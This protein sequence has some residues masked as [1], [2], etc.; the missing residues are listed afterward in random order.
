[1]PEPEIPASKNEQNIEAERK[2]CREHW[3]FVC[4]ILTVCA[5]GSEQP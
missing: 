3:Q 4:E 5:P 2:R 1:M